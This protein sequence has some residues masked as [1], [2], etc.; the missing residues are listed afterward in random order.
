M[1]ER[2]K[3]LAGLPYNAWDN[4][5]LQARL[6]AKSVCHAFNQADPRQPAARM[7]L[8]DGLL[9]LHGSAYIEPNFFCDY[10]VNIEIGDHFYANHNLTI[11]DVCPVT[12]AEHVMMGPGCMIATAKHPLDPIE[13]ETIESGAPVVIGHHVWL[14]GNV[15]VLPGVTIGDRCVIG[16]G[17]VVNRDIPAG[18]VAAGNPARVIRML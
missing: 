7:A 17:S 5:L 10:G 13:R 3:M 4:E 1:T 18:A 6:L 12:I 16:A 2:E 9:T 15:S 8:L 14:G 11:L